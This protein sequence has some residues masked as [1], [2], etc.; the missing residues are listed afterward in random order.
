M[1]EIFSLKK[2][3]NFVKQK[4]LVIALIY[5]IYMYDTKYIFV[6]NWIHQSST[7]LLLLVQLPA[8][9]KWCL[10]KMSM[11]KNFKLYSW[12][13][14][15][16]QMEYWLEVKC[17]SIYPSIYLSMRRANSNVS[18]S[19]TRKPEIHSDYYFWFLHATGITFGYSRGHVVYSYVMY[20]PKQ[21]TIRLLCDG[22]IYQPRVV[23]ERKNL[24]NLGNI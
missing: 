11:N 3:N 9:T 5:V 1:K 4:L 14:R 20:T 2:K 15:N 23:W 24:W 19:I 6:C 17:T 13:P 8:E 12:S 18:H 10:R 7:Y 21:V 22:F 16:M